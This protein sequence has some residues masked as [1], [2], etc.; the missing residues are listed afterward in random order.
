VKSLFI[1]LLFCVPSFALW[2]VNPAGGS[3]RARDSMRVDSLRSSLLIGT[4]ANGKFVKRDSSRASGYADS[5]GVA[6][7]MIHGITPG[8]LPKAASDSTFENSHVSESGDTVQ[9]FAASTVFSDQFD[10]AD[11]TL[12]ESLYIN[13]DTGGYIDK[14]KGK[15]GF[16]Y[17]YPFSSSPSKSL[18]FRSITGDQ[19]CEAVLVN[20]NSGGESPIFHLHILDSSENSYVLIFNSYV[21]APGYI[22]IRLVE[23]P[24]G[25]YD[26][27]TLPG[28][29]SDTVT[30]RVDV[31]GDT[32][33]GSYNGS[34]VVRILGNTR[35]VGKAG[36]SAQFLSDSNFSSFSCG[37][38]VDGVMDVNGKISI[39]NTP[40]TTTPAWL[41]TK[42]AAPDNTI[43]KSAIGD[44]IAKSENADMLDGFHKT[45][46]DSLYQAAIRDSLNQVIDSLKTLHLRVGTPANNGTIDSTGYRATGTAI[47][48]EDLN[49]DP[50]SSGG[51]VAT[52]PDPVMI[53]SVSYVEFTSANNQHCGDTKELPHSSVLGDS[54]YPHAHIF[55]K[56]GESSGATGVTFTMCW[57][58]RTDG[59]TTRGQFTMSATSAELA[60]DG[61]EVFITGPAF[62]RGTAPEGQLA[63]HPYRTAGDAGDV[64]V[65]T[66]GVHYSVDRLGSN[67]IT[68]K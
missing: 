3:I 39:K 20:Q 41:L 46:I 54:L 40:T 66:Y 25:E 24:G 17:N 60:A 7:I 23:Y 63:M 2:S 14:F 67:L 15:E 57:Q 22:Y 32:V 55:L 42:N 33:T 18:Y 35:A 21:Y 62:Y 44:S 8:T 47:D 31:F 48:W 9:A 4:D 53:D 27:Y 29:P 5:A 64:V 58:L 43:Y 65:I 34:E 26:T 10:G 38:T 6:R 61:N 49:F 1:I 19:Y 56:D 45:Q 59:S 36:F 30:I 68:T 12:S 51:P 13:V 16:C 28:Y 37:S 52:R 11:Q 50:T